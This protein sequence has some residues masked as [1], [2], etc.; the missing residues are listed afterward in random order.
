M[1]KTISTPQKNITAF[2]VIG[3]LSKEDYTQ[4][5]IPLMEEASKQNKKLNVLLQF[6]EEFEGFTPAAAWEDFKT[7]MKNI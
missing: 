2:S 5:L 3:L 1:F 6:G 7:G 4:T